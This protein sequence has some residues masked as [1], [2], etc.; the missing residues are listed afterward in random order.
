MNY[1]LIG[2]ALSLWERAPRMASP[3]GEGCSPKP[4]DG[5]SFPSPSE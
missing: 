2:P 5:L 4:E 1:P 3:E